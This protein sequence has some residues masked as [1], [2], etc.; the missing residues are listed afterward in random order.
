M[1]ASLGSGP[2][3]LFDIDA[4]PKFVSLVKVSD[5]VRP[6]NRGT[7]WLTRVIEELYDARYAKDLTALY[8]GDGSARDD[9]SADE[10]AP[11]PDFVFAFFEKRYGLSALVQQ[12]C[13]DLL[14]TVHLARKDSL[15]VET[16]AR[17]LD[18][19]YDADDLLY[20]L[21]S[22]SELQKHLG[23]SFRTHAAEL[24]RG[25]AMGSQ[26]APPAADTGA[27]N[28]VPPILVSQAQAA[29][30]ARVVFGSETD[31]LFRSFMVLLERHFASAP[32]QPAAAARG[33]GK[34]EPRIDTALFLHLALGQYHDKRA[35]SAGG[36]LGDGSTGADATDRLFRDALSAYD[37]RT[38]GAAGSPAAASSGVAVSSQRLPTAFL[39]SLGER[40]NRAM[41]DRLDSL[42]AAA[43]AL[44]R[45]VY[46]AIRAEVS[47]ALTARVD[48]LL[49]DVIAGAQRAGAA[50][51]SSETAA[52]AK[53]FSAL[54][55]A[56]GGT[57]GGGAA[58]SAFCNAVTGAQDIVA[59]AQNLTKLLVDHA[60]AHVAGGQ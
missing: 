40:M 27:S 45:E 2:A 21:Y 50:G 59:A 13:W 52:L 53:Q 41:E 38:R 3:T 30:V 10:S 19:H 26:N 47:E 32:S 22:R 44:P 5:A 16:F 39:E 15:A 43:T 60:A 33:K 55:A 7:L 54:V 57:G 1:L 9:S 35:A 56:P 36:V 46:D 12:H 34:A 48:A 28:I 51:A 11:F 17:F 8:A 31:A 20:F 18:E 23:I 4:Y 58:V 37:D 29:V 14:Y 49:S 6:K 25:G 42:L 24:G